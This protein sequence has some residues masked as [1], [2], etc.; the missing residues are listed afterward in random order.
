MKKILALSLVCFFAYV[1]V[2]SQQIDKSKKLGY[3]PGLGSDN[4]YKVSEN[5]KFSNS[6]SVKFR[7]FG[8][9]KYAVKKYDTL[10]HKVSFSELAYANDFK[11]IDIWAIKIYN[12]WTTVY[13]ESNFYDI[14]NIDG[15][16]G[17]LVCPTE[18]P[19]FILAV[20]PKEKELLEKELIALFTEAAKVAKGREN[21]K[22]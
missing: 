15:M 21:Y 12:R 6:L 3:L 4:F 9:D 10:W 16:Y 13:G 7:W 18:Q 8:H 2:F 19:C 5:F 14:P 11:E 1:S 17:I 20:N 22:K